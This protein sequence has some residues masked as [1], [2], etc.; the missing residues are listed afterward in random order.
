MENK[1]IT[2][3]GFV[4]E[5]DQEKLNDWAI[6]ELLDE[7]EDDPSKIVRFA[8]KLLGKEQYDKLKVHCTEN[9]KVSASL[10]QEN[11]ISIMNGGVVKN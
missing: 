5:L 2:S 4:F 11:L 3:N 9:G 8:R 7:I 10:M 6:L 1:N